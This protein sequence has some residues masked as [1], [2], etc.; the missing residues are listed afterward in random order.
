LEN[1]TK[2]FGTEYLN[3]LARRSSL[4]LEMQVS[5]NTQQIYEQTL[6]LRSQLGDE[7]AFQELLGLYGPH[8]LLFARKMM[9]STPHL[10]E[11]VTQEV[12]L[13]IYKGLPS[14]LDAGKF[15]PWAFRIARDRIYRE[16][17]RHKIA[18]ERLEESHL[19][20]VAAA[21]EPNAGPDVEELHRGL[22]A[23]SPEHREALVLCFLEEMSYE[24]IAGVTGCTLGT[25]R[26]RIHYAKRA[27]KSALERKSS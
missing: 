26:S 19:D 6:V 25:V 5:A 21:S 7:L 15:R 17:R 2:F 12:W 8:L 13:A 18:M 24:E 16:Y 23:L 27:L 20:E 3:F 1:P 22:D 10:I 4:R 11:D 14:L 9:Q